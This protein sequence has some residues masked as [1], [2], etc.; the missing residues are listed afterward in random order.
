MRCDD[1]TEMLIE[2]NA[3]G[4]PTGRGIKRQEA[5]RQGICHQAVS[6]FICND[7]NEILLQ[8]RSF[9]KIKN[10]GL[11]DI[12][13]SGHCQFGETSFETL[14]R[15]AIE[16]IKIR[17]NPEKLLPLAHYHEHEVFKKDFIE[18]QFFDIY[19][20][21]TDSK[22][23]NIHNAEVEEIRW[24]SLD[25]IKE[26]MQNYQQLAYKPHAFEALIKFFEN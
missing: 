10:A 21:K 3:E 17:I 6:L 8:K 19:L 20:F 13:V 4:E 9:K 18:N 23:K 1:E 12:S 7:K 24:F 14:I 26:M 2:L 15:E 16:E 22:I 25:E 5:H 11:W